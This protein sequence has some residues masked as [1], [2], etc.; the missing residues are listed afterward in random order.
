MAHKANHMGTIDY[1]N[2]A[3]HLEIV[4]IEVPQ[5]DLAHVGRQ[6]VGVLRND[7]HGGVELECVNPVTSSRVGIQHCPHHVIR[8]GELLGWRW[9]SNM[10]LTPSLIDPKYGVDGRAS[11]KLL[12]TD[13]VYLSMRFWVLRRCSRQLSHDSQVIFLVIAEQT[14]VSERDEVVEVGARRGCRERKSR[15]CPVFSADPFVHF[16]LN[17]VYFV[18]NDLDKFEQQDLML[19]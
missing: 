2:G 14:F 8:L 4:D 3:Q 1:V 15:L 17:V 19:S 13:L 7:V 9:R 10:F 5:V 6:H 11:D 16:V 18:S 12:I